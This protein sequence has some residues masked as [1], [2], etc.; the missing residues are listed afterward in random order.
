MPEKFEEEIEEIIK[1][2]GAGLG[3]RTS[4]SDAFADLQ[5]RMREGFITQLTTV[6]H[7]ATPTRVG[8]LG[9]VLLV[10]GLIARQPYVSIL[11][12]ALL[13]AA[14]L[15]SIVRS[16]ESFKQATGYERKWRG[17]AIDYTAGERFKSKLL[18]WFGKKGR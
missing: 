11:A 5:K 7:W 12:V 15:L 9:A 2:R 14:Y 10:A 1:K 17:K 3:P 13:L 6:L 8:G 16:S 18:R 4:L